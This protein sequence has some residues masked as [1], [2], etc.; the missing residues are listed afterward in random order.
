M[1]DRDGWTTLSEPAL[2]ELYEEP[3]PDVRDKIASAITAETR[4]FIARSSLLFLATVDRHGRCDCTP[5]G[6]AP[7]FVRV[8]AD[9]FL[10]IPDRPGNRRVDSMHNIIA[11]GQAGVILLITG[12]ADA[13]RVNGRAWVT[14]D[15]AVTGLFA[16]ADHAGAAIVI[17][18]DEVFI[19]CSMALVRSGAWNPISWAPVTAAPTM[20]Q[21]WDGHLA[22]SR[23]ETFSQQEVAVMSPDGP[24]R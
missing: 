20:D 24:P 5:R 8:L 23:G 22:Q 6:D 17:E 1:P 10:V 15:P 7:G 4:D 2:R 21:L 12:R 18:A 13:V 19:H 16:P 14:D 11:T 3:H 9:R